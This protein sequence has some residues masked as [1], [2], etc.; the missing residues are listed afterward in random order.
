MNEAG[1]IH[2]Y[3]VDR[4]K[5]RAIARAAEPDAAR[6][7]R[8]ARH[9]SGRRRA[10]TSRSAACAS[11]SRGSAAASPRRRCATA[12]QPASI[13][14]ATALSAMP[15]VPRAGTA[16]VV[17]DEDS[18][19]S[20]VR[21]YLERDGFTV[22]RARAARTRSASSSGDPVRVVVLDVGLPDIDGFDVCRSIRAALARPDPD[23]HRARRGAR[24]HHAGSSSAPT[25]T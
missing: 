7:R 5:I 19:A 12:P 22:V 25:T 9:R 11:R 13:V 18:I 10:P 8:H 1:A 2:D 24:P 16:L 20:L 21:S 23:A 4:G 14:E 3:R 6:A 17:E 15:D